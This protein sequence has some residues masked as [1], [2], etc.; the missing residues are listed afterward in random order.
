MAL[1]LYNRAWCD[2]LIK[3]VKEHSEQK[4]LSLNVKKTKIMSTDRC[5]EEAVINI[6]REEIERV[7]NYKYLGFRIQANGKTPPEIRR[8]LAMATA[9]SN[10][11]ADVW[12]GQCVDTK[13]RVL[14]S[15]V[16]LR[17]P[18]DVKHGP[19]IKQTANSLQLLRWNA[20]E[21]ILRIPW[22]IKVTNEKV[23]E[24]V[25][26]NSAMLLHEIRKLKVGY[27]GHIKRHESLEKHILEAKAAGRRGRERPMRL[28]EQDIQ[29]WLETTTTQ[30]GRM[31][32]DR[33]VFRKKIREVTSNKGSADWLIDWSGFSPI[34]P[35][36]HKS[37]KYQFSWS[38]ESLMPHHK[39][40]IIVKKSYPEQIILS[41][42]SR[43]RT[44]LVL[45]L[46]SSQWMV[47]SKGLIKMALN[48]T[49]YLAFEVIKNLMILLYRPRSMVIF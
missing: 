17:Q 40:L 49:L 2:I 10:K 47:I 23:L 41:Q 35:Q 37:I 7:S 15:T 18:T 26:M 29:D 27:F 11:M 4:G 16:F 12:K 6:D 14:K 22:T 21:K 38:N 13:I 43:I 9:K 3:S 32:E 46:L 19:S 8:R 20:T 31:A 42:E 48:Q 1:N 25:K 33:V 28:W 36:L 30:A 39:L 34:T 24:K 45:L 5:R 44:S